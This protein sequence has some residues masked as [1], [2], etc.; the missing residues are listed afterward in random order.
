MENRLDIIGQILWFAIPVAPLV[1]TAIV[2]EYSHHKKLTR[3]LI[4]LGLGF[5][6][7]M[8]LFCLSWGILMRDGLGQ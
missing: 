7:S 3:L 8:I 6:I 2:W 4:G 5:C 1:T